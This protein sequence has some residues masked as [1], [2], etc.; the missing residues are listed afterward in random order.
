MTSY[1]TV[2]LDRHGLTTIAHLA[3]GR[4]RLTG[5]SD[6]KGWTRTVNVPADTEVSVP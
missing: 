1:R 4:Y 6:G 5:T 3:R 2:E